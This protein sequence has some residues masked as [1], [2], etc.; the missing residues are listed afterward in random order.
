MSNGTALILV[1]VQQGFDDPKWGLRNNLRAEENMAQLLDYGRKKGWSSI[2]VQH[3]SEETDSPL[4]PENPGVAFKD[5]AEPQPN[6][7]VVQKRV[8]SAFIGTDLEAYLRDNS[9]ET[10]II[11]GLTTPHCVSTTARMSGNLGFTT[12]VVEDATA[13]FPL[14]DHNGQIFSA[15]VVHENALVSLHNEFA[16][17][18]RTEDLIN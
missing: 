6:E 8:N 12:I 1:D 10:N 5:F 11:V 9:I 16:E 17:I 18:K 15:E 7:K 13:A 14:K 4:H 2:H 3:L